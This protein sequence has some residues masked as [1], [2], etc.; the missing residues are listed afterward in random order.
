M[1]LRIKKLK[2]PLMLPAWDI[3]KNRKLTS[4]DIAKNKDNL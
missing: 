1:Y 2:I 4:K 3:Q